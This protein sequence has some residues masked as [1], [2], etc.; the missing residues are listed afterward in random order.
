MVIVLVCFRGTE[1][2]QDRKRI[3]RLYQFMCGSGDIK[4]VLYRWVSGATLPR[5]GVQSEGSAL[6]GRRRQA[7]R[8]GSN[9]GN[10]DVFM[11]VDPLSLVVSKWQI[12]IDNC[13]NS[14]V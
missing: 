14:L 10:K 1:V 12:I 2:V 9:E 6:I 7:R 13:D 4:Q 8:E 11:S 3:N 5:T